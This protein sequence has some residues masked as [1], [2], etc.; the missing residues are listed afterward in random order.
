MKRRYLNSFFSCFSFLTTLL[1]PCFSYAQSR[2]GLSLTPPPTDLSVGYLSNIFGMVDGVL[3]GTGGQLLGAMFGIFNGA[4]LVLGCIVI[5]YTLFVSTLN[6]AQEGEVLGKRWSSMW[7]P[8]RSVIGIA[9]L[10]PKASGYSFIQI[11]M[12]WVTVMGVGA[13]DSMWNRALDYF[14]GGGILIQQNATIS[15]S[16]SSFKWDKAN[17]LGGSGAI[18]DGSANLLRSLTCMN[19]LHTQLQEYRRFQLT[20]NLPNAYTPVPDFYMGIANYLNAKIGADAGSVPIPFIDPPTAG[21]TNYSALNGACGSVS[22]DNKF[23]TDNGTVVSTEGNLPSN[24]STRLNQSRGLAVQSMISQLNSVSLS[25]VRNAL[26]TGPGYPLELGHILN[27]GNSPPIWGGGD[28]KNKKNYLLPGTVLSDAT[29]SYFGI[30][31]PALNYAQNAQTFQSLAS[32]WMQKAKD[33]GW[34]M[35]GR[36]Y[37]DVIA[38]NRRMTIDENNPPKFDATPIANILNAEPKNF[39]LYGSYLHDLNG[40]VNANG[41]YQLGPTSAFIADSKTYAKSLTYGNIGTI[42]SVNDISQAG[43]TA[44]DNILNVLSTGLFSIIK[45]FTEI[46]EAQKM[47]TNPIVSL[48]NLGSGLVS[49]TTTVFI[50][51]AVGALIATGVLGAAWGFTFSSAVMAAVMVLM[52][53]IGPLL[54]VLLVTGATMAYYIPIIPFIIFTFGAIGWLI[55]VVECIIAAPLVALGIAHPE[56][57]EVLGKAEPAVILLMNVFLRP[58]FMIFGFLIGMML[59][60]VGIWILNAGF[61]PAYASASGQAVLGF[62]WIFFP[63]AM[64]II[65]TTLVMQ[66]VQK[67]FSLIHVIPDEILKWIGGNIRSAGGEGEAEQRVAGGVRSGTEAGGQA[68]SKAP[69]AGKQ[70]AEERAKREESSNVSLEEDG[71]GKGASSASNE[72]DGQADTGSGSGGGKGKISSGDQDNGSTGGMGGGGGGKG[73]GKGGED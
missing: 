10:I 38:L 71:S 70:G 16:S 15:E 64:M 54:L 4:V 26:Q 2:E 66:V 30:M 67:S 17:S 21:Q 60:Y 25:I 18:L 1:W 35:A 63:I 36:Y 34:I 24:V 42:G 6:T 43:Q 45:G 11:F 56:G 57:Q 40:L 44:V 41:A 7:I 61:G 50:A 48:A 27:A 58:V 20:N 37:Y 55:S 9:L 72:G 28:L 22:W 62:A 32:G 49:T 23:K 3:A 68:L 73:G 69:D 47:N 33:S 52:G 46:Q 12:M 13:A 19:M 59:A 39:F 5:I 29:T 53:L 31:G 8:L 51:V 14:L 65:Y